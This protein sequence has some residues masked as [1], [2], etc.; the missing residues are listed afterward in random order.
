MTLFHDKQ[1]A[2]PSSAATAQEALQVAVLSTAIP[3]K[4]QA[5]AVVL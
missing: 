4:E 2:G 3:A 5:R 1:E